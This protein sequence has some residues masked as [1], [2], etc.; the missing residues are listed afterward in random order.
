MAYVWLFYDSADWSMPIITLDI[1]HSLLW[2]HCSLIQLGG[3]DQGLI[4]HFYVCF[5]FHNPSVC[6]QCALTIPA[7]PTTSPQPSCV[8][9]N[10]DCM[11]PKSIGNGR[12]C[13]HISVIQSL[14]VTVIICYLSLYVKY[15]HSRAPKHGM[16]HK[17]LSVSNLA[18][19]STPH[20][21]REQPKSLVIYQI[22]KIFLGGKTCCA[23]DCMHLM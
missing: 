8:S 18:N 5:I 12:G 1:V 6:V 16:S 10:I 21:A 22:V 19:L 17:Q 4:S 7:T 11:I 3:K 20:P 2:L 23:F 9:L 13:R 14:Y 15:S